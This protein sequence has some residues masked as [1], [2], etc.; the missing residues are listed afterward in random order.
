MP[1][2][3]VLAGA[4]LRCRGC[5]Q[6][7][8]PSELVFGQEIRDRFAESPDAMTHLWYHLPC[9]AQL[10]PNIFRA[11]LARY[12]GPLPERQL[13]TEILEKQAVAPM[14]AQRTKALDAPV[15]PTLAAALSRFP[16]SLHPPRL[17]L[18]GRPPSLSSKRHPH[19]LWI[20]AGASRV[21]AWCALQVGKLGA[22]SEESEK[23]TLLELCLSEADD[24]KLH[25]K[26]KQGLQHNPFAQALAKVT[27]QS[28]ATTVS[29]SA[30]E[31]LA[32]FDDGRASAWRRLLAQAA[33]QCV[34]TISPGKSTA[35]ATGC[36][37]EAALLIATNAP[38]LATAF[39]AGLDDQL[40]AQEAQASFDERAP[41][42]R[43]VSRVF[44]RHEGQLLVEF[45][46]DRFGLLVK[47]KARWRFFEGERD[48]VLANVPDELFAD[49]AAGVFV[50]EA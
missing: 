9:A 3:I 2:T 35:D 22:N 33:T 12:Q 20:P 32:R 37:T 10:R 26:P 1:H 46:G 5:G 25:P 23:L 11:T 50:D 27:Q 19:S 45:A 6:F 7:Y 48:D 30:L 47:L 34:V 14:L 16:P 18:G 21:A 8:A 28:P 42:H 41:A 43:T 24:P 40:L 49:A 31:A 39:L 38:Q 36:A 29:F 4:A 17:H 15:H 44:W 13:V